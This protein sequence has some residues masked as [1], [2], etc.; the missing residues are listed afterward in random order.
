MSTD[1]PPRLGRYRPTRILGE[2]AVGTVFLAEDPVLDRTVTIKVIR[3]AGLD[4]P[5]RAD[6]LERF[7]IEA[8][9]AG[10]C[11]HPNI[12]ALHDFAEAEGTPFIVMEHVDGPNLQQALHD[13]AWRPRLEPV[14]VLLQILEAL[15]AAHRHGIVHRDVKPAN[16]LLTADCQVKIAD[17]GIARLDR[18]MLT[19]YPAMIGTPAYMAPEQA[20][21]GA[22]DARTDLFA[23][24]A[25]LFEMLTG[26]PPF[27]GRSL[28]ETLAN[29][30]GP[31]RPA[32]ESAPP[33]FAA[34]L[35]Q[36]LAKPPEARF[37]SAGD[38]TAALKHAGADATIVAAAPPL[39]AEAGAGTTAAALWG[40]SFIEELT[41]LLAGHVG[42]IAG[43]LVRKASGRA[44]RPDELCTLLGE[45][46][47][48]PGERADFLRRAALL[49]PAA[50]SAALDP[51]L[52]QAAEAALAVH[53]GPIAKLLVRQASGR[54]ASAEQ[55]CDRLAG[56]L[57]R[58]DEAAVFR[59][60]LAA[61]LNPRPGARDL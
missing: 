58:P 16:I 13:G 10:R 24:G 14:A 27:L 49:R 61:A 36:A 1:L 54:S 18:V 34:I 11:S 26:R 23:A 60:R 29:L 17:F 35:A 37:Q 28:D 44:T 20:G 32:L 12:V 9:A 56:H 25:I 57:P 21:G 19:Q 33:S 59:R 40:A 41:T 2:G 48:R 39:R 4:A 8:K 45:A 3:T 46:L 43:V 22:I 55:F 15:G 5:T 38:F 52:L 30:L 51:A 42:P 50:P 53:L 47:D 6:Y 31:A 7:R